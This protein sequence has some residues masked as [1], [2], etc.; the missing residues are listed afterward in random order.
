[1][2]TASPLIEL[3]AV[4]P[5]MKNGYLL[6]CPRTREAAYIDPGDEA[7][8]MLE[9]MD[10]QG[11]RLTA[12]YNTHGH[13][14]HICGNGEVKERWDVPIYLHPDDEFL[15][16]ALKKQAEWFGFEYE[17][18]PPV[19][20]YLEA[21]QWLELGDLKI[22]VHHT[23]GH[24]P[25]SVSL[26]VEEHIFCGDLIFAGSVGRTDLPGGAPELLLQVIREKILP[27]GEHKTLHPG[28]GPATTVGRER[29]T[30]P[31]LNGEL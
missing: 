16:D 29:L 15:Y 27:L 1:M 4:E 6:A 23:P 21:G 28:H 31:F 11:L 26:E 24:S 13:M 9:W 5:M 8:E 2:T 18:A 3:R 19:D 7:S 22:Q 10:G 14:D 12:I 17:P 20:R 25:G 30:N